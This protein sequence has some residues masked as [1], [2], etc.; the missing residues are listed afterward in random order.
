[1]IPLITPPIL[2]T[3]M[4]ERGTNYIH[5]STYKQTGNDT[6]PDHSILKVMESLFFYFNILFTKKQHSM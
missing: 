5:K 4:D 3:G 1:M 2:F 6:H